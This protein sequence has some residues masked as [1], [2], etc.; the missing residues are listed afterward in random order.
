MRKSHGCPL[1]KSKRFP[2]TWRSRATCPSN[3]RAGSCGQ[4]GRGCVLG[5]LQYT[6]RRNK[7]IFH[8]LIFSESYNNIISSCLPQA[9]GVVCHCRESLTKGSLR[10]ASVV[11]LAVS[12]LP[13]Q[14]HR[15]NLQIHTYTLSILLLVVL[16]MMQTVYCPL[17]GRPMKT[18]ITLT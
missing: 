6:L 18:S 13:T 7:I 15:A 12:V 9:D 14:S 4:R 2:I 3:R 11:S 10:G 5:R 17:R 1:T 8:L 16:V